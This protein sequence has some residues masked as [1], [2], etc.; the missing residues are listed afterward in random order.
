MINW[1]KCNAGQW[2]EKLILRKWP[3]CW[4]WGCVPIFPRSGAAKCKATLAQNIHYKDHNLCT[5]TALCY[6]MQLQIYSCSVKFFVKRNCVTVT[7][8]LCQI[9]T[10][11]TTTTNYVNSMLCSISCRDENGIRIKIMGPK[12][13]CAWLTLKRII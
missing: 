2:Y 10:I 6:A 12:H 11:Q 8:I 4:F 3:I 13:S 9:L 5:A 1:W 7:D